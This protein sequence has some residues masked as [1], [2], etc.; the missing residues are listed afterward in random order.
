MACAGDA[1]VEKEVVRKGV[2]LEGGGLRQMGGERGWGCVVM[3]G[4]ADSCNSVGIPGAAC[5]G[6]AGYWRTGPCG[7]ECA[8]EVWGTGR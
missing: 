3:L 1:C 2:V 4:A 7:C 8:R 5:A 6:S